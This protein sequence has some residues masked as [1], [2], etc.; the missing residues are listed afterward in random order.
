MKEKKKKENESCVEK[1][2]DG[3]TYRPSHNLEVNFT[4]KKMF[5]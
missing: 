5:R 3:P 1:F 4:S 2:R